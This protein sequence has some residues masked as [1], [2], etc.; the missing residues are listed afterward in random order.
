MWRGFFVFFFFKWLSLK[1]KCYRG[2]RHLTL[3]T[4]RSKSGVTFSLKVSSSRNRISCREKEGRPGLLG[5][6]LCTWFSLNY[7]ASQFSP[8]D[9]ELE[10][11]HCLL[12]NYM[13]FASQRTHLWSPWD[14]KQMFLGPAS[15][16]STC[17]YLHDAV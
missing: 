5:N 1:I 10:V 15:L 17:F 14:K 2:R 4:S 9:S 8:E 16:T 13:V 6:N 3:F 11:S 12:R 7:C